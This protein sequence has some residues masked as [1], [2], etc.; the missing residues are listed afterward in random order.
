[1]E[2]ILQDSSCLIKIF[3][4]SRDDQDIVLRL[5]EYP[6]LELSS[7]RNSQDI[8]KFVESETSYLIERGSLLAFSSIKRELQQKIVREVISSSAGM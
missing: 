2:S 1:M 4:S 3:V 6:N 5:Q 8:A 7:D